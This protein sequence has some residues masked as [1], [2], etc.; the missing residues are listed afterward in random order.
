M[1][2]KLFVLTAAHCVCTHFECKYNE[3]NERVSEFNPGNDIK[4]Y[5]GLKDLS[6]IFEVSKLEEVKR[7]KFLASHVV[8]HPKYIIYN[9]F[10]FYYNIIVFS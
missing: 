2:N 10:H 7:N 8:V 6:D 3:M 1:I 4:V 5:L 9:I